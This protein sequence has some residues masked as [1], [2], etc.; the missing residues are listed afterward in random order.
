MTAEQTSI[1]FER[2]ELDI[3]S[4]TLAGPRGNL[5][6]T[7]SQFAIAERL[8]RRPGIINTYDMLSSSVWPDPDDEPETSDLCIRQWMSHLRIAL[9]M[10]SSGN[11]VIR[12]EPGVGWALAARKVKVAA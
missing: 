9:V 5:L 3:G 12:S 8:F 1:T 6:L 10:I 11:V 7:K 4:R 2:V